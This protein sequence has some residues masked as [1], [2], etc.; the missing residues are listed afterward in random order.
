MMNNHL[1][2]NKFHS[3]K[4]QINQIISSNYRCKLKYCTHAVNHIE[5]RVFIK[6]KE[7]VLLIQMNLK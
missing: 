1:K 4:L 7:N 3:C 6:I 2:L 5:R